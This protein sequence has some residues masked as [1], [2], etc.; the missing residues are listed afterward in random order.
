[1]ETISTIFLVWYKVVTCYWWQA[2]ATFNDYL[3]KIAM[4]SKKSV[5]KMIINK[6]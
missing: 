3:L 4:N 1:M 6:G 2:L 5:E